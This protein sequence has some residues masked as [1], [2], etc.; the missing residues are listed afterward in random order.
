MFET[1]GPQPETTPV[2]WRKKGIPNLVT[3]TSG[4]SQELSNGDGF[5]WWMKPQLVCSRIDAFEDL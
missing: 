5:R 3:E 4:M 1:W 2:A